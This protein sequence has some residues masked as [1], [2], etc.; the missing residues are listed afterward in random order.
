M[1][2]PKST[3]LS[4]V[5]R[6]AGRNR[7]LALVATAVVFL[8]LALWL[9]GALG[10]SV[11]N[12]LAAQLQTILDADVTAL[13]LWLDNQRRAAS[14][15]AMEP[16]VRS[17]LVE[18][19]A[20]D[21]TTRAELLKEQASAREELGPHLQSHEFSDYLVFDLEGRVLGALHPP[22][23]SNAEIAQTANFLTVLAG[24]ESMVTP[25]F[26]STVPTTTGILAHDRP[27]MLVLAPVFTEAGDVVG[28]LAFRIDP[29]KDFTRILGVARSGETGETYAFG[30]D[31]I[32][33]SDSRFNDHLRSIGLLRGRQDSAV[34][35]VAVRDPGGNL[36]TGYEPD[37]APADRP[38]TKMVEAALAEGTGLSTDPYRDY[39]GVPVIGAWTWLERY[40]FGV[41]TEVD[42]DEALA[43]QGTLARVVWS[44]FGLLLLG[45]ILS[46]L[47]A[48]RA[49]SIRTKLQAKLDEAKTLGAYTL[50]HRIGAGGFGEV[51]EA[52][53][54]TLRRPTAVKLLRRETVSDETIQ[55][56]EREAQATAML[57]SP[58]TVQLFDFGRTDNGQLYYVMERLKGMDLEELLATYGPQPPRRVAYWAS[59]V[60]HSL[61]EAH[62]R[63][64]VHR[65]IKPSNIF[66]TRY[67]EELDFVK[68]LDFGLVVEVANT[69]DARLTVEGFTAGTA[70]FMSPEQCLG[71][72]A[73]D[74]RAD[75]YSLGVVMHMA[76]TNRSLFE[77]G[78]AA[79]QLSAHLHTPADFGP[80]G[81]V[82]ESLAKLI[83]S[84]VAKDAGERP[85]NARVLQRALDAI[86]ADDPWTSEDA[87]VWW[88]DNGV[89]GAAVLASKP[90]SDSEI[91]DTRALIVTEQAS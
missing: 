90:I 47:F 48:R 73:I 32:M 64:L 89:T 16:K 11:R 85:A 27:T 76:L 56:F 72:R 67:G 14:A 35:R 18:L 79:E 43:H 78:S 36:V 61:F 45:G 77:G 39:R 66:I 5:L 15:I 75:L 26:R 1:D 9:R 25:P 49:A 20:T 88:R 57:T 40:N 54:R 12:N 44:L 30:R 68:I 31:G 42:A 53:H 82:P 7:T 59:Q 6:M 91:A 4:A 69:T 34:L 17:S 70:A 81:D 52:T 71:A 38:L 24:G 86:F 84:C 51:Y 33:L 74:G 60:C 50:G 3:P 65:D 62:R 23:L 2:A 83:L 10:A 41:A 13:E 29:A 21:A 22:F 37:E 28:A 55:R 80:M 87:E 46:A 19:L 58:H 63:G 8:G